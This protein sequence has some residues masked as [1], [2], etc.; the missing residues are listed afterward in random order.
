MLKEIKDRISNIRKK[1]TDKKTEL[2][3][4]NN[5]I[6]EQNYWLLR[7]DESVKESQS[8]MKRVV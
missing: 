1:L 5:E 2:D 7:I 8:Q 3:E 4:L 6:V